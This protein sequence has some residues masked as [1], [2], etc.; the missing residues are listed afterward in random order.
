MRE[1]TEGT[2]N[3]WR[4]SDPRVPNP[5]CGSFPRCSGSVPWY[6]EYGRP[7]FLCAR[8]RHGP[9]PS[10][11]HKVHQIGTVPARSP[12]SAAPLSKPR[13]RILHTPGSPDDRD[14][15]ATKAAMDEILGVSFIPTDCARLH[16]NPQEFGRSAGSPQ[17]RPKTPQVSHEMAPTPLRPPL[18]RSRAPGVGLTRTSR[19]WSEPHASGQRFWSIPSE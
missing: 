13:S 4:E 3:S 2:G 8:A 19:E 1:S 11:A 18:S 12:S 16:K 15:P 9:Y 7:E 10:L 6:P 17:I 5:S 14:P